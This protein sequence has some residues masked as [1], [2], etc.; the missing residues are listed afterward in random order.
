M[1]VTLKRH[2]CEVEQDPSDPPFRPS[3][4]ASAESTFPYH[5]KQTLNA[6]GGD[7]IK[8]R[9]SRDGHM[10]DD[11]QQY[12]RSR[13]TRPGREVLAIYSGFY[14]I[15]DAGERFNRTGKVTLVV[16]RLADARDA[17]GVE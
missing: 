14:A 1:R 6:Q 10:V 13:D 8:K 15:E 12:L 17:A 5:V 7:F 11:R 9:M 16:E 2:V 3:G 4:W